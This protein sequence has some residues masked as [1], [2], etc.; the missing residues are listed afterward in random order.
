MGQAT[1]IE[2]TNA[3]WNPL[4][5][6]SKVSPGCENCYAIRTAA[7]FN[8]A[9]QTYEGLTRTLPLNWTGEVREV[10]DHLDDPLRWKRP[11]LVFVNSMSDL[12]HE[13]VSN[14]FI[15]AV[16]GVMAAAPQHTFQILTKR[17]WRMA[18]WFQWATRRGLQGASMFPD[19]P[20]DWR[21]RQMCHVAARKA[22]VDMNA[23]GRQNHGG[24][25]PLPNVWL[26]VSCEDQQRADERIPH[27][28]ETPT[29]V[30]FL[31]CEPLLGPIDLGGVFGH[32]VPVNGEIN[33][34]HWSSR[35]FYRRFIHWVIVGGESGPSARPMHPDW[36]RSIRGQCGAAKVPFFF[37]QWG[38]FAVRTAVPAPR[39]LVGVRWEEGMP[40]GVAN[41]IVMYRVG[42]ATAGRL[43]DGR[44][45]S[46]FPNAKEANERTRA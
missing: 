40:D 38:E 7:R 32:P 9:G 23:D 17:A 4:R 35:P 39:T 41:E 46:E 15:A 3:T 19:D 37:K 20:L 11:R 42:K 27:L 2:W 5:G 44:E 16:F 25:W 10:P 22:G 31:S 33:L 26:G 18:D 13:S 34:T 21:I 43:L 28:L 36:V 24:P 12:F 6:C 14:E 1:K 8:G 30:R 29:A 45:W